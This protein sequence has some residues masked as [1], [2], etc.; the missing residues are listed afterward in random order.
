MFLYISF[1]CN[2][3]MSL[4]YSLLEFHQ[5]RIIIGLGRSIYYLVSFHSL[6]KSISCNSYNLSKI[7]Q[8]AFH[9]A[10][11]IIL[12][13]H[14]SKYLDSNVK[15]LKK[16]QIISRFMHLAPSLENL[17]IHAKCLDTKLTLLIKIPKNRNTRFKVTLQ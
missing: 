11:F 9:F 17:K 8:H 10:V 14:R 12:T 1:K 7:L 6:S 5:V 16:Y 4:S 3:K 13:W 2:N 15:D